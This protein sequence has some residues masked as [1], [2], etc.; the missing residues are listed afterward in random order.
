MGFLKSLCIVGSLLLVMSCSTGESHVGSS[1]PKASGAPMYQEEQRIPSPSPS[2]SIAAT[3]IAG[4]P[5]RSVNFAKIAYPNFPVYGR[6][7][8]KHTTLK[9]GQ[10]EP[11]HISYGDVTKD[12]V[13]EAMVVL[14]IE[15]QG[16]AIPYYVYVF[17]MENGKPK[18]LW[19]FEAGDRA[20]G[21]LRQ[22][23]ADNGQLV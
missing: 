21:G 14:P 1:V 23:Y 10:G 18:L 5:I 4:S 9:P 17:T 6:S 11:S 13:E 8:T 16:S 3:P 2:A 15:T 22:V 20:D 19:D 12:G 7:E